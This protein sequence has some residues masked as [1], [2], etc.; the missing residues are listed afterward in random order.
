MTKAQ[1]MMPE[2]TVQKQTI[3]SR[4]QS[5]VRKIKFDL[6][7]YC[8]GI[9]W[10]FLHRTR[11]ARPY[12]RLMCRHGLYKKFMDGRCMWCGEKHN[13]ERIVAGEET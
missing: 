3:H 7:M 6:G 9:W 11:L 8:H 12:S 5:R 1:E 4:L 13:S 2:G 10:R